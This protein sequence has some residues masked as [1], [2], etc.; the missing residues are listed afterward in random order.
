MEASEATPEAGAT[1]TMPADAARERPRAAWDPGRRLLRS[2]RDYQA[3]RTV[4]GRKLAALRHRFWSVITSCELPL[5]G[6]LGVGLM[7]PHPVGIVIHPNSVIGENCLIMH[8]VT[9]GTRGPG[10]GAPRLGRGVDVGPG[11]CL[12]G[13]ITVGDGAQ[14]GANAVVTSDVPARAVAVGVPARV[15]RRDAR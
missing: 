15:V 12:L 10:S 5:R 8:N 6:D 2:V 13:G 9:L 1:W 7:L 11:A 4:L 3:A 14:V